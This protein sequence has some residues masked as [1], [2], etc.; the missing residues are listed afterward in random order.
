METE[1]WPL[2]F[3]KGDRV[4]LTPMDPPASENDVSDDADEQACGLTT[5]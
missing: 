5:V 2:M 3:L 1:N 4:R